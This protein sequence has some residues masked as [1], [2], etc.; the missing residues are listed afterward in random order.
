MDEDIEDEQ[1]NNIYQEQNEIDEMFLDINDENNKDQNQKQNNDS[2][3]IMNLK[4]SYSNYQ[5]EQQNQ[6]EDEEYGY[7]LNYDEETLIYLMEREQV[8]QQQVDKLYIENKQKNLTSDMRVVLF[9]W[10]MQVAS[11]YYLKRETFHIAINILDRFLSSE[12][13][14][15][16]S[17]FQI[18]GLVCLIISAKQ[19][20]IYPPKVKEFLLATENS[21]T[22]DDVLCWEKRILNILSW[23][24]NPPTLNMWGNFY[25]LQWDMYIENSEFASNHPLILQNNPNIQLPIQFKQANDSSYYYFREYMQIIDAVVLDKENL[26]YKTRV[27][28]LIPTIQY[29]SQFFILPIDV[30]LPLSAKVNPQKVLE[31]YN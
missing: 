28:L 20:E 27:L 19:E 31:S 4:N 9:D 11:E 15:K 17:Q 29:V 5:D 16:T 23:Q 14:L 25:L 18:V 12:V 21:Y 10:I 13:N 6:E 22:T 8:Y 24:T 1:N 2:N 30:E 7:V 26:L 3:Q